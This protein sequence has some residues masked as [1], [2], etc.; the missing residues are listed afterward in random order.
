MTFNVSPGVYDRIIDFMTGDV[1]SGTGGESGNP[2]TPEDWSFI[3]ISQ[4]QF[5]EN[6]SLGGVSSTR[7]LVFDKI[8]GRKLAVL[9]IV[10]DKMHVYDTTPPWGASL[11]T[12]VGTTAEV[13]NQ[14]DSYPRNIRMSHDGT[15]L[16]MLGRTTRTIYRFTLSIP[17]DPLSA[18]YDGPEYD[19]LLSI[20]IGEVPQS[21]DISRDGTRLFYRNEAGLMK[22][23]DMS[24]A[25]NPSTAVN[26]HS[27]SLVQTGYDFVVSPSGL[28]LLSLRTQ[29]AIRVY[30]M[31]SPWDLGSITE[32]SQ[33]DLILSGQMS[34]AVALQYKYDD[35]GAIYVVNNSTDRVWKYEK[36]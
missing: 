31:D 24:T 9:D 25:W 10:D 36:Q 32:D 33:P 12:K 26:T 23:Y 21:F 3:D 17:G 6:F 18:V 22:Q 29:T 11:F 7:G 8:D 2:K 34:D 20:D 15:R 13:G 28:Q 35:G 4:Y 5:V 19:F 14:L 27:N 30:T 1:V 16:F